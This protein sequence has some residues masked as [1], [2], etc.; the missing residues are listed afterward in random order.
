MSNER[1]TNAIP[2]KPELCEGVVESLILKKV[3]TD[4]TYTNLLM[5]DFDKRW[6]SNVD[7]QIQLN[8]ALKHFTKYGNLPNRSLLSAYLDRLGE[9]SPGIKNRKE[10]ILNEFDNALDLTIDRSDEQDGLFIENQILSFIR[11]KSLYYAIMDNIERIES[12]KDP[13]ECIKSFERALGLSLYKD[14]GADY[15]EEISQHFDDMCSPESKIPLGISCLDRTTNGGISADG[16]CLVVYMAQP[17]LGKSLMLSNGAKKV[18]D[19]NGFAVVITLELSEKM[20]ARRFSAHISGNHIDQLRESRK[21][22]EDKIVDYAKKHP[23]SK[24]IIKRFPENSITTL[25]LENYLDKLIKSCDRKPDII[26]VDYL[27]LMLPKNKSYNSTMYERVGDVARDL[28]AMSAKFK[29][30][31]V[32]ATQV[33]TE[34]YNTSNV[35]LQNT[36][37]SKGIAHT[38]DVVIALSQEEDDIEAGIINAKFLKNRYGKN[39]VRDRLSID[40]DTLIIDAFVPKAGDDGSQALDD[41]DDGKKKVEETEDFGGL[42]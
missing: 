11:E 34:G 36:S 29:R 14:L 1:D 21:D 9:N 13:T 30:P 15:L 26:F 31:I 10:S 19:R 32:T 37:E 28:R 38:A 39:H 35:G 40:Y 22:A 20:Y 41:L 7:I 17:C 24:L 6:F 42:F 23:G 8:I 3:L 2:L 5:E 4:S 16:D 18:L 25:N 27:N 12:K 33:N